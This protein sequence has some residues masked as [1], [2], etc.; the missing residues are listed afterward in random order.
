[1]IDAYVMG[2]LMLQRRNLTLPRLRYRN[3]SLIQIVF[4]C[5]LIIYTFGCDVH[6]FFSVEEC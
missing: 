1:M 4:I 3:P 2:K 5:S 6:I